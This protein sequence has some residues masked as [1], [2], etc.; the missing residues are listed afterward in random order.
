MTARERVACPDCN[1]EQAL[2]A[3]AANEEARCTRCLRLLKVP[4]AQASAAFALIL[5][6]LL[7]WIP[8][9]LAPLLTVSAGGA[10]H[11]ANLVECAV[12]LWRAGYPPL[13]VLLVLLMLAIPS[14]FMMLTLAQAVPS[15]NRDDLRAL[16]HQL[17]RWLMLE[18]FVVGG[19]VAYSRIQAV[20]TVNIDIGGWCLAGSALLLLG[21]LALRGDPPLHTKKQLRPTN[22]SLQATTA[23]VIAGLVLYIPANVLPVLQIERY[24]SIEKDTILGGVLELVHYDL[25][26]L[27]VIVFM[28]SVVVPLA[29][30]FGLAWLLWQTGR[31]SPHQLR[32][33]T[34]IY[35]LID[36][37]GRWSN[38]DVFMISILGALVQFGALERV[39]PESGALAFAGVVLI[40]MIAAQCFDP[41]LM[42]RNLRHPPEPRT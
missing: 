34:R 7:F 10:S 29:K 31:R 28:A 9:C 26:P 32:Q 15:A 39:R 17:R 37:I 19:C 18:V 11:S 8:G 14:A 38:I 35:R 41:R 24:G 23:L 42:W 16:A 33:R 13:S 22:R 30:L 21:S 2:P 12:R 40:T 20:A 36:T 5:G 1:L 27:A 25:W 6:A 3:L 4:N